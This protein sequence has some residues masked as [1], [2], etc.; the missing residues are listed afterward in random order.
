MVVAW[1]SAATPSATAAA[2]EDVTHV[3]YVCAF[4]MPVGTSMLDALGGQ[5]PEWW[6]FAEDGESIMPENPGTLL[7]SECAPAVAN[8]AIARLRPHSARS[9]REPLRAAGYGEIPATY[10]ISERDAILPAAVAEGVAALVQAT[11]ISLD[12]DH[13]PMLSRP[14]ELARI[15][16]GIV[17]RTT[18]AEP[19]TSWSAGS[20]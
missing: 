20:S 7:F 6:I 18:H 16:A 1:T 5:P 2:R 13:H 11:T 9:V 8:G 19:A 14:A 10:V 4:A 17:A 3:V 15:L 12:S